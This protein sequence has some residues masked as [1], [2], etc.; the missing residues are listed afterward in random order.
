M[1]QKELI[2]LLAS[3]GYSL[4]RNGH[5]HKV[6]SNGI[7]TIMVPHSRTISHGVYYSIIKMVG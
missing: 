7:K 4:K 1:K 3:K 2:K 6:F 5:K